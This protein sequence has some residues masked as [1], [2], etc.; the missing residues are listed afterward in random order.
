MWATMAPVC[1]GILDLEPVLEKLD[2]E[3]PVYIDSLQC[4][5]DSIQE[6]KGQRNGSEESIHSWKPPTKRSVLEKD[7]TLF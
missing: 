6:K 3:I 5:K 2:E 1:P 7:V 4:A